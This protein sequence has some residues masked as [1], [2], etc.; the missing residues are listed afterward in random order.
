MEELM[1]YRQRFLD[2]LAAAPGGL[3]AASAAIADAHKPLEEGGW[4]LHQIVFHLRDVNAQVYL[5]RLHRIVDENDPVFENFDGEAWMA[6]HY[7]ANA[8]LS[9][10]LDEFSAQCADAAAWLRRLPAETWNRPGTH[11]AFGTH[12]LQW[13][14]ERALAHIAEH[15]QTLQN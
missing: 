5:P 6:A 13:W 9:A 3:R 12:T 14:A 1:E 11:P 15:L 4:N 2:T 10:M 8:P 7:D